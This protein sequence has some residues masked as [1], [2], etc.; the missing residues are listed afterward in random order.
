MFPALMC[1]AYFF[2]ITLN[3]NYMVCRGYGWWNTKD[4]IVPGIIVLIVTGFAYL[5]GYT[6]KTKKNTSVLPEC[7]AVFEVEEI[8]VVPEYR[9]RGIGKRLFLYAEKEVSQEAEYIMLSTAT[10]NWKA[11]LH[12]YIEEL[13]MEFWNARLYKKID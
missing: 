2:V 4:P 8:Y 3:S 13:G 9:D 10:K 6:E 7:T 1:C 12:F 11:I 5:F